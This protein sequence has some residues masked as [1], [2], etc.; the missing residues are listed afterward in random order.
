MKLKILILII[1]PV[2]SISLWQTNLFAENYMEQIGY[3]EGEHARSFFGK[4]ITSL[5]FNGDGYDDIIVSSQKY[6]PT[7]GYSEGKIYFYLGGEVFDSEVDFTLTGSDSNIVGSHVANLGDLNNDG[8]EDLGIT[9]HSYITDER[10]IQIL[11]GNLEND[12]IPDFEMAFSDD[13]Y[14]YG[15]IRGLGDINHDGFDDAGI[16]ISHSDP[17]IPLPIEFYIVYGGAD[18]LTLELFRIC[19][20]SGVFGMSGVGDINND[21]FD[22]FCVGYRLDSDEELYTNILYFGGDT[23]DTTIAVTLYEVEN[24][25]MNLGLPAGD[26]NN[27]SYADFGGHFGSDIDIWFGKDTITS[28][29]DLT[30]TSGSGGGAL[31]Y[32]FAHGDL[33]NDGYSDLVIGSPYYASYDGIAYL[34]MGSENPNNSIDLEFPSYTVNHEWG[35]AVTIGRFNG[36]E[37]DDV[38]I[39]GPVYDVDQNPGYVY[40]FAGNDSLA[41]T[42]VGVDDNEEFGIT[43]YELMNVYPN[44]STKEINFEIKTQ[45][46]NY[47]QIQIY[48]VKGQL[49]EKIN[50]KDRNFVWKAKETT[51]GVYLCK[52]VY[53]NKVLEVKKVT[54]V[55]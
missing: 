24:T 47:L 27:D 26:L 28:Q 16:C 53:K 45:Y 51:S 32:A 34:Y 17:V 20:E 31:D 9:R 8:K 23:I 12:T 35:T 1:F 46:I 14:F 3:M 42:T 18:S 37:Y 39:S 30:I 43:N 25:N 15:Y 33:N 13:E 29:Y 4:H 49:V 22:D 2:L 38:A 5:D 44:P 48:N 7:G 50:V 6:N 54:F 36:D 19:G 52:L 21:G 11:Y 41:D 10:L 55:K 40:V